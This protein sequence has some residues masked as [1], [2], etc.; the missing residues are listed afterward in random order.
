MDIVADDFLP[1]TPQPR[2]RIQTS[3]PRPLFPLI[4]LYLPLR[5]SACTKQQ[6]E[7]PP[8]KPNASIQSRLACR[9]LP[10]SYDFQLPAPPLPVISHASRKRNHFDNIYKPDCI[11]RLEKDRNH[12]YHH[13]DTPLLV[14]NRPICPYRKSQFSYPAAVIAAGMVL[15]YSRRGFSHNHDIIPESVYETHQLPKYYSHRPSYIVHPDSGL[16]DIQVVR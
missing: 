10:A 5:D 2:P 9:W 6:I 3:L 4:T 11:V 12:T 13:S 16:L 8:R 1:P 15:P 7:R 14:Y